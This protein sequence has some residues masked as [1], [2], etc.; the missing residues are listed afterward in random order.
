MNNDRQKRSICYVATTGKCLAL[1]VWPQAKFLAG[2]GWQVTLVASEDKRL[3][4][5]AESQPG[6]NFIPFAMRR[7]VSAGDAVK[8]TFK[9]FRLFRREKFHFV[10]YF[11]P[12]AAFYAAI[13]AKAAGIKFRYYQ[14]GGLRYSAARGIKRFLL[15]IPDI[16]ACRCSTQVVCVSRGNLNLA[17]RDRLFPPRKGVIIGH[18]GSKGV[19]MTLFDAARKDEWN[20]EIRRKLGIGMDKAVIGFAGS[21]RRDKGCGEL[22]TAFEKLARK[23]PDIMLLLVGDRDFFNTI[24]AP[25]RNFAGKSGR[26][27]IIP[28]KE[29]GEYIPYEEM[30]QYLSVFDIL[31]FPSYREGLPNVV[32]EVQ[33][34]G[35][36][37]VVA[38]IPGADE[39]FDDGVTGIG[40]PAKDPD[41]LANALEILIN[42]PEKREK[43][44]AQAHSF[45]EKYFNQ[46]ILLQQILDEKEAKL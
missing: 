26:V 41:A 15:K 23:Y 27:M 39:A 22:L 12:N 21:I 24:P 38:K 34:L 46:A 44:G 3:R 18:G 30:P 25:Q 35:I 42:S 43:M 16:I 17:V 32:I 14:L 1:F 29:E 8:F 28:R 5:L 31:A 45:V 20:R 37:A 33:A 36:P 9:L 11:M 6:V 2:H 19:D 10:Q 4:R 7:R 13:A 40:I